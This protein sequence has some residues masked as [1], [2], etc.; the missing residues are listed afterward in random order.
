MAYAVLAFAQSG[1][2]VPAVLQ[3]FLR[4]PPIVTS[5]PSDLNYIVKEYMK[6]T[7]ADD[8]KLLLAHQYLELIQV[9]QLLERPQRAMGFFE[10]KLK[11]RDI[12]S[13]LRTIETMIKWA[14]ASP[15]IIAPI[16]SPSWGTGEACVVRMT[17][18]M[19]SVV[20]AGLAKAGHLEDAKAVWDS[21]AQLKVPRTTIT[22]N[23][24]LAGYGARRRSQEILRIWGA[25]DGAGV[26]KDPIS[27]T[28][29][30]SGLFKSKAPDQALEL[31]SEFKEL[32]KTHKFSIRSPASS[33]DGN[34]SANDAHPSSSSPPTETYN[35]VLHGLLTSYRNKHADLLFN[36]MCTEGPQPDI[37]TFNTFIRHYDRRGDLKSIAALLRRLPELKIRPD[38][39]TFT[40]VLHA[41]M[42]SNVSM[43]E[44]I[45]RVESAMLATGVEPNVVMY[46]AIINQ[47]IRQGGQDNVTAALVWLDAM[48]L[49]GL[50]PNEVTYTA[51]LAAIQKDEALGGEFA[52]ATRSKIVSQMLAEPA[53]K[54][55]V[56]YNVLI[57][58]KLTDPGEAGLKKALELYDEMVVHKVRATDDTWYLLLHGALERRAF[59]LGQ[60][61][62]ERM[63]AVGF[64]PQGRVARLAVEMGD[65][66]SGTESELDN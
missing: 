29:A 60:K 42:R 7:P 8:P 20:I 57:K 34:D 35:A 40:S 59:K 56:T 37:T 10:D 61:I 13:V 39:F 27:Y 38:V 31:F 14:K 23:A 48:R 58:A 21:M 65:H 64:I 41:L 1:E 51:M 54:N 24:L 46:T 55:R 19:W 25:M 16:D 52:G 36:D 30:I 47:T 17:E 22:W 53:H 50:R 62:L 32:A 6:N 33:R 9:V 43:H 28:T 45:K 12:A 26:S 18:P 2:S 4:L 44:A 5:A 3:N 66:A 15:P 49:R 11:S 63:D